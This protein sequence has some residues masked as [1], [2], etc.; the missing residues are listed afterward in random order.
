MPRLLH[1]WHCLVQWGLVAP[2]PAAAATA[3]VLFL[4]FELRWGFLLSIVR[5]AQE[6]TIY[7]GAVWRCKTLTVPCSFG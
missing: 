2:P 5:Q 1:L 7:K 4:R 3:Y 6:V